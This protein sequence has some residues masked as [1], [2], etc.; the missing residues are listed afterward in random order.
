[1]ILRDEVSSGD[2]NGVFG[3][4]KLMLYIVHSGR[5]IRS[6]E[7]E[8]YPPNGGLS[9]AAWLECHRAR[10]LCIRG[11]LRVDSSIYSLQR[12]KPEFSKVRR[13]RLS[14]RL[15]AKGKLGQGCRRLLALTTIILTSEV[16]TGLPAPLFIN[17]IT[18]SSRPTTVFAFTNRYPPP[19]HHVFLVMS[20]SSDLGDGPPPDWTVMILQCTKPDGGKNMRSKTTKRCQLFRFAYRR[21]GSPSSSP[22]AT[23]SRRRK[24]PPRKLRPKHCHALGGCEGVADHI[25]MHGPSTENLELD[26]EPHDLH[27]LVPAPLPSAP[28]ATSADKG[29]GRAVS[30]LEDDEEID[31]LISSDPPPVQDTGTSGSRTLNPPV[32]SSTLPRYA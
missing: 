7:A 14:V 24:S 6:H 30:E 3:V 8:N 23:D 26:D 27:D 18:W 19:V 20:T 21:K 15:S 22:K 32:K 11:A 5:R 16:P 25:D 1:M 17:I 29:K 4:F 31:Q 12:K 10:S 9:D 28:A 13:V 2:E